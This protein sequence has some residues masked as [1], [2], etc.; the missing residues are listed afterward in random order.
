MAKENVEIDYKVTRYHPVI[1]GP[2]QVR[3][4]RMAIPRIRDAGPRHLLL[5]L[6]YYLVVRL[7]R[8]WRLAIVHAGCHRRHEV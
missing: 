6:F 5:V 2:P 3:L 7:L 8:D 4:W 1:A